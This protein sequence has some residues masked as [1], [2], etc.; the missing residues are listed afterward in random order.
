MGIHILFEFI[1]DHDTIYK[2]TLNYFNLN[3]LFHPY[4]MHKENPIYL[5]C[6]LW[7]LIT[8]YWSLVTYV[9][10]RYVEKFRLNLRAVRPRFRV[11]EY[12]DSYSI[13]KKGSDRNDQK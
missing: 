7:L 4:K 8:G 11:P 2:I 5:A 3:R 1:M 13:N 10:D 9:R 12:E 6:L